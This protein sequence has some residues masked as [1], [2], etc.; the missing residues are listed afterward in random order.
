MFKVSNSV[1]P[2]LLKETL[3][4]NEKNKHSVL[5]FFIPV[6]KSASLQKSGEQKLFKPGKVGSKEAD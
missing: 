4:L 5:F 6:A 3:P 1:A 2:V